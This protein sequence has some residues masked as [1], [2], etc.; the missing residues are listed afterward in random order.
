MAAVKSL[1]ILAAVKSSTNLT[2]KNPD[3]ESVKEGLTEKELVHTSPIWCV[4]LWIHIFPTI[5]GIFLLCDFMGL[6]ETI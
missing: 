2:A 5:Q 3:D 4:A 6:V 1:T